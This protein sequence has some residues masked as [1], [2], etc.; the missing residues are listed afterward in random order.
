MGFGITQNQA[1]A[2]ANIFRTTAATVFGMTFATAPATTRWL[3]SSRIMQA[4]QTCSTQQAQD[5]PVLRSQLQGWRITCPTCGG[6]L[7]DPDGLQSQLSLSLLWHAASR[8]EQLLHREAFDRSRHWISPA[9]VARLPLVPRFVRWGP[10]K[11]D[12][13]RACMLGL[14]TPE[15][16]RLAMAE[17]NNIANSAVPSCRSICARSSLPAWR[18][19]WRAGRKCSTCCAG[20]PSASDEN[21]S[22]PSQQKRWLNGSACVLIHRSSIFENRHPSILMIKC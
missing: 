11:G 20:T 19:F 2:L 6:L 13:R 1:E 21:C 8:G 22:M 17:P 9:V 10:D 18:S 3:I 5:A 16:D 15:F 7:H 14:V 4:C 12:Y